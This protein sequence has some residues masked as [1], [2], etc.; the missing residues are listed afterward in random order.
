MRIPENVPIIA[1]SVNDSLPAIVVE[2]PIR[3]APVRF[4]CRCAQR[5]AVEGTA[6]EGIE[7]D[8]QHR[9]DRQDPQGL[10]LQRRHAEV[11]RAI[12]KGR[13]ARPSAPK[14]S[15]P[16]PIR[17]TCTAT[18]TISRISTGASAIGW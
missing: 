5:L 8:D 12:G 14:K 10:V 17:T 16:R 2:M 9:R 7:R 1:A 13:R 11:E 15:R 18:E 4:R 6:E 3:R